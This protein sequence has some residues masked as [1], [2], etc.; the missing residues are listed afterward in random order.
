MD[1]GER[2]YR[3]EKKQR[4]RKKKWES[5]G[6][7]IESEKNL[8]KLKDGHFGCGCWMC[9]PWKHG[10]EKKLKPSELRSIENDEQD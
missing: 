1:R 3:A 9:K 6:W 2:R 5:H 10:K 7:N 4:Q 8:G